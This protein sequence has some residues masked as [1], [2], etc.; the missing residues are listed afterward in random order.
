MLSHNLLSTLEL[1]ILFTILANIIDDEV[2]VSSIGV[3][4]TVV[5]CVVIE[6]VVVRS[7]VAM[8]VVIDSVVTR[9]LAVVK[10]I[11]ILVVGCVVAVIV[12]VV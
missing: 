7:I 12:T 9:L 6:V 1:I 5:D 11:A 8:V 4:V 10:S 2:V 3:K